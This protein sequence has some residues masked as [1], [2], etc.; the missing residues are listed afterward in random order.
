MLFLWLGLRWAKVEGIT[1]W[2]IILATLLVWTLQ[3]AATILIVFM[4]SADADPG[5]TLGCL[6]LALAAVVPCGVIS[7]VLRARFLRAIQAWLPTLVPTLGVTAFMLLAVRP[8]LFEGFVCPSNAMAPSL[9][10]TH[11]R[12]MCPVCGQPAYCTPD[13]GP[14]FPPPGD[15]PMI[16]ER[17]HTFRTTETHTQTYRGDRFLVCKL[18]AP[19]RWDVVIFAWPEDPSILYVKRLVGLPGEEVAVRDDGRVWIDGHPLDPPE[20]LDGLQYVNKFDRPTFSL[21]AVPDRPA[22]L[23]ADEYF[24][25][26]DFSLRSKDSRLWE[27][28][29]PGHPPYAVPASHLR[30][31]VTHI[32][33]PPT[34]W[35]VFR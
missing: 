13:C 14:G 25:L 29:A 22:K 35:K 33:W 31:V 26:G 2:R 19:K 20:S 21:W 7:L 15:Y 6:Q 27:R 12:G 16:C 8:Y 30:G 17:F 9:L 18:L 28:G 34:R 24:V 3:G 11:W 4:A 5:I 10:G 1:L 23:G 32:Y